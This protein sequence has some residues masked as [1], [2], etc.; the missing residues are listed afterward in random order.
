MTF[1]IS[2]PVFAALHFKGG[3]LREKAGQPSWVNP[4]YDSL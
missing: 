2:V 4:E 3:A 1:F